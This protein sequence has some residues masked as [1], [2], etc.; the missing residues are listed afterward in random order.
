MA[1]KD[2]A[3][4]LG[5]VGAGV[6]PGD[7][8]PF[9]SKNATLITS[10]T[11]QEIKAAVAGKAIYVTQLIIQ[12]RTVAEAAIITIQDDSGTPVEYAE[13]A[14][15]TAAGNAGYVAMK[16]EPP[17]QVTTGQALDGVSS[18]SLGDTVVHATGYVGTP[19]A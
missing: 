8:T 14:V 13:V 9:H 1:A 3:A 10:T 6:V 7:A 4:A 17:I 5:L 11:A 18:G 2:P 16:F 19:G 15:S 12:N